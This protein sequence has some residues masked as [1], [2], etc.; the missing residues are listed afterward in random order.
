MPKGQSLDKDP[1]WCDPKLFCQREGHFQQIMGCLCQTAW[2]AHSD[3]N[4]CPNTAVKQYPKVSDGIK[5]L[6]LMCSSDFLSLGRTVQANYVFCMPFCSSKVWKAHSDL[7]YCPSTAD[8]QCPKA[9]HW[10]KIQIDV[11]LS[12]FVKG[13]GIPRK[14][15]VAYAFLYQNSLKNP[16]WLE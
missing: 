9:S 3:W 13:K 15:W 14:W 7:N 4:N 2:K 6:K 11:I 16:F 10:T 8:K 12:F 5:R 1:N